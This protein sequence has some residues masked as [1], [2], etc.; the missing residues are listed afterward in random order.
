LAYNWDGPDAEKSLKATSETVRIL[1]DIITMGGN[2][3]L[4]VS[5]DNT[6]KI[7]N[8]Q[9]DKMNQLGT[10]ISEHKEAIY[11]TQSGLPLG[12][13]NGGSTHRGS[14]IYLIAYET[15]PELVI[16]NIEGDIETITHLKT[17]TPLKWRNM[18][19]Y[20]SD[21]NRKGWR[22][23]SLPTQLV[24]QYGT[25]IK[26]TFKDKKVRIKNPDKTYLDW[27]D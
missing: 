24:E 25:V 4:N 16:K 22:F 12:L 8:N 19:D 2:L 13:F 7:S 1:G 23:I 5:P 9:I 26:I 21:N 14:T 20:H 18:D 10:W 3:L 27:V 11:G 15:A 6:G 17:G